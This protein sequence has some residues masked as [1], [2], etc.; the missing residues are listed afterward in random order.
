[1]AQQTC[2]AP[3]HPECTITCDGGCIALYWEPDGP[4]S[5]LCTGSIH[6][7]EAPVGLSDRTALSVQIARVRAVHIAV[8]FRAILPDEAIRRLE[9][10]EAI[11]SLDASHIGIGELAAT[12]AERAVTRDP[13]R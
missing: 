8:A 1:M 2:I 7:L 9:A 3:G 13:Q 5:T 6:S 12:L 10:S 4:C 11:I